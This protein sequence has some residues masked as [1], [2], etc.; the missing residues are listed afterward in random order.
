MSKIT[1]ADIA[2]LHS[3]EEKANKL[4]RARKL[5]AFDGMLEIAR[6]LARN[7]ECTCVDLGPDPNP[8]CDHCRAKAVIAAYEK[9]SHAD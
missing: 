4:A 7:G 2:R 3:R 6:G 9:G 8:K 5:A 1:L